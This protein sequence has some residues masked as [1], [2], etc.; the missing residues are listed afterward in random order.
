ML[1]QFKAIWWHCHEVNTLISLKT[2]KHQKSQGKIVLKI[3]KGNGKFY[4]PWNN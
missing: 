2:D 1:L 4:W 3:K